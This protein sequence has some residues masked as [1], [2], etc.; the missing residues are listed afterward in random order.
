MDGFDVP[1]VISFNDI[2]RYQVFEEQYFNND[3]GDEHSEEVTF[4]VMEARES[5]SPFSNKF[6]YNNSSVEMTLS[7]W[8]SG[9]VVA[10]WRYEEK[11]S[12]IEI[13]AMTGYTIKPLGIRVPFKHGGFVVYERDGHGLVVT[14]SE[15]IKELKWTGN[16]YFTWQEANDLCA[17]LAMAGYSDW[18][19][20]S[21]EEL[22]TIFSNLGD[23][24]FALSQGYIS[25]LEKVTVDLGDD[26]TDENTFWGSSTQTE[27][28]HYYVLDLD[29]YILATTNDGKSKRRVKAVRTF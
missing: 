17:N 6:L 10:K 14:I 21:G 29:E 24:G 23:Y 25:L 28:S 3:Y 2:T 13:E 1:E 26:N 22:T 12:L 9:Q 16:Q 15:L 11:K 20:P 19:L 27:G 18:R 8:Q 7:F 4:I 5:H